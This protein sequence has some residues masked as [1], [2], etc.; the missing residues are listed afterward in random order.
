MKKSSITFTDDY[1][2]EGAK[3]YAKQQ[4]ITFSKYIENLVDADLKKWR[5]FRLTTFYDDGSRH[6]ETDFYTEWDLQQSL[7][8]YA[9]IYSKKEKNYQG[10]TLIGYEAYINEECITSKGKCG[11]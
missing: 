7:M 2:L 8:A 6:E 1:M 3:E 4:G 9:A 5:T 10:Q 11:N